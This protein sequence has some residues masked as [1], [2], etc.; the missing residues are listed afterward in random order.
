MSKNR[1]FEAKMVPQAKILNIL[2][3][4]TLKSLL[5]STLFLFMLIGSDQYFG[6]ESP[7]LAENGIQRA[8]IVIV[9]LKWRHR[10]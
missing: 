1:N 2:F 7:K 8:K 3:S 4:I 9:R 6:A 5:F 10:L